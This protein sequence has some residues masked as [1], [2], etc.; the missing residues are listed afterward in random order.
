MPLKIVI[1]PYFQWSL[2][3]R[4]ARDEGFHATLGARK[5]EQL[6]TNEETQTRVIDIVDRMRK[7]LY[8]VSCKNT[9][10]TEDGAKLISD[11]YGW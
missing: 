11:A 7:D 6:A 4:I 5:L 2:K 9:T 8:D 3:P 1:R 10:S